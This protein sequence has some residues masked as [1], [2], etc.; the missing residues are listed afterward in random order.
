M[1]SW[2]VCLKLQ[3]DEMCCFHVVLKHLFPQMDLQCLELNASGIPLPIFT[4]PQDS[5]DFLLD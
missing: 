4:V 2:P 3:L 5:K 1:E